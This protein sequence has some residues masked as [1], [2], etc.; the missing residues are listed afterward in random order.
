MPVEQKDHTEKI[1]LDIP[2][3]VQVSNIQPVEGINIV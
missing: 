1:E 3:E 2:K